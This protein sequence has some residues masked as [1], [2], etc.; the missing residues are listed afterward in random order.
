MIP[1]RA[2]CW[3]PFLA[4]T[5]CGG[6]EE[7]TASRHAPL[8]V[9]LVPVVASSTPKVLEVT[10]V[11]Q[12]ADDLVA[13]FQVAGRLQTLHVDIGDTVSQGEVLAELDRRDFELEVQ[14]AQALLLQARM[15][16]GLPEDGSLSPV[17]LEATAPVREAQAVLADAV[18]AR[19]RS[20]ELVQ[21]QLRAQSE[22]DAANAAVAVAES[23][24][25]SARDE[26]RTWTAELQQR[27]VELQEAQKHL[28]DAVITSPWAGRVDARTATA[29]QYVTVGAPVLRLLRVDPLRLR[30]SVPERM[31]AEVHVGQRVEFTVD[32]TGDAGHVG[33]VNRIAPG[34]ELSARTLGVEAAVPNPDGALRAGAFARAQI[35][36]D[37]KAPTV[38]VPK[39]AVSSFAG[40]D[41]LFL[42][43]DGKAEERLVRLGRELGDNVEILAGVSVGMR[44]VAD[45]QG[46]FG[47]AAVA[48]E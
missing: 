23:K 11:L 40:V 31:A 15:R 47:G 12:P 20:R 18:L 8:A 13:G 38:V 46:L 35:V 41:R 32:G 29:G 26:V 21:K 34:I 33:T 6:G 4:M 42:V 27:K 19:D 2:A 1:S 3:L 10:G 17:D 22:L 43:V 44:V 7:T 14:K 37:P 16:L 25:Q 39:T 36:V 9:H 45:G 5:A 24:L 48:V 28:A 30:L